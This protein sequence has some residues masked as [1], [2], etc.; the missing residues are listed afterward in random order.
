MKSEYKTK[1]RNLIIE[2][3]KDNAD[4]RFT[5]R[6]ILN[7]VKGKGDGL[8]RSTVYRNLGRLSK[9]GKLVKYKEADV[10]A[11]CYQYSEKHESCCEHMH[12]QCSV[13]GKIFHLDNKIFKSAA[14]KMMDE[15]GIEIDYGKSVIMCIC[16]ECRNVGMSEHEV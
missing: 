1:P 2:Y 12:A 16:D 7:A 15:Y 8:D 6:D 14:K 11:T 13:C 10:N 9:E 3:L 4:T 5:A